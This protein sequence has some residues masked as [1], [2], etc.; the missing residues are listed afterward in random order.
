VPS[1]QHDPRPVALKENLPA[2]KDTA[3]S[4]GSS[5]IL[6]AQLGLIT[7]S[8]NHSTG[9]FN[10]EG[11]QFQS[12]CSCGWLSTISFLEEVDLLRAMH[13]HAHAVFKS[14]QE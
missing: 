4:S 3:G 12:I 14:Y 13:A 2:M 10:V 8:I 1:A 11:V 9:V 7:M 6:K 5:F